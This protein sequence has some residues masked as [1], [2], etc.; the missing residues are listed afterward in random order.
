MEK[1]FRSIGF[2]IVLGAVLF[3]APGV[4]AFVLTAMIIGITL[5]LIFKGHKRRHF[6][7]RFHHYRNHYQQVVPI[8]N[9][10]YRPAVQGNGPVKDINVNY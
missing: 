7:H 2:G 6:M 9:Q 8:D 3:F 10:W 5:I 4:F 1:I